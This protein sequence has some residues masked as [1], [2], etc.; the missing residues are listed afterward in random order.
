MLDAVREDREVIVGCLD[1]CAKTKYT[2][3]FMCF[4]SLLL[5]CFI[6]R[7]LGDLKL[8]FSVISK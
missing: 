5:N 7:Y 1:I 3:V 8:F 4:Q 2:C 6:R